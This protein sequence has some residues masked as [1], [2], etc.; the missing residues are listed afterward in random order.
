MIDSVS[1]LKFVVGGLRMMKGK[2]NIVK[3]GGDESSRGI[4]ALPGKP[5]RELH[6]VI[7]M[8]P[9]LFYSTTNTDKCDRVN[10]TTSGHCR[11][12]HGENGFYGLASQS[13]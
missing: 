10:E 4:P 5:I 11:P 9:Q 7:I 1:L 12:I 3:V 13:N 6:C 8:G 2:F